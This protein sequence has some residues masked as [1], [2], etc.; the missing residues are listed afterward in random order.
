[1]VMRSGS[2]PACSRANQRPVRPNPVWISSATERCRAD[3]K[4]REAVAD[5]LERR[6]DVSTFPEHRFDHD[7][8]HAL[9][10]HVVLEDS[11][12]PAIASAVLTP[13]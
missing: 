8:C 11:I 3:H 7:G 2:I 9:W 4:A 10:L 1:M 12:D 13:R 5:E 6:G